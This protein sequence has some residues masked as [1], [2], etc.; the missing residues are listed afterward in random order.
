MDRSRGG[1]WRLVVSAILGLALAA[2]AGGVAG[3]ADD[4]WYYHWSCNGDPDCLAT[5]PT[6]QPSGTLNEGPVQ[7]NCT[8]LMEFARRFWGPA[9]TNSCDHDPGGG[10]GPPPAPTLQ[11]I[12]VTPANPTL[13]LG[14]TRQL[15][16][17]GRYSD[18][19]SRDLTAEVTWTR[20]VLGSITVSSGGLVT[21]VAM[22]SN[23]VVAS[24][25]SISGSTGVTVGAVAVLSLTVTPAAATVEVGL[26][27]EFTAAAHWSDGAVTDV[28]RIA[29]WWTDVSFIAQVSGGLVTGGAPGATGLHVRYEN[30]FAAADVTVGAPTLVSIAVSPPSPTIASGLT[31]QFVATGTWSNGTFT[32]LT[33]AVAWTSDPPEVATVA[34]GGLAT[35][36]GVG[37]AT[38]TATSGGVAGSA[39]LT[40]DAPLLVSLAVSPQ[41]PDA[42]L[43]GATQPFTATGTYT[44]GSTSDLTATASWSS[45]PLTVATVEADGVATGVNPGSAVITA[46]SG[47]LTGSATLTVLQPGAQW[48]AVSSGT[49]TPLAGVAWSG[50]RF[51]VVGAGGAVLASVDGE[52]W[53]GATSGTSANLSGVLWTGT[54][55]VAVGAA[56][57]VLTSPD[58]LAWTARASGVAVDL[59]SVDLVAGLVAAGGRAGTFITSPDG[60]TWTARALPPVPSGAVAIMGM[61]WN[62]MRYVAVG[63]APF[64]G[65]M[66][67]SSDLAA[68]SCVVTIAQFDIAVREHVFTIAAAY[69]VVSTT[70]D[71]G[72]FSWTGSSLSAN[73]WAVAWSGSAYAIVGEAGA[74]ATSPDGGAWTKRTSG[75]SSRLV[76]LTWAGDRLV[77]VGDGGVVLLSP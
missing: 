24:L 32:D 65:A 52:A 20:L 30:R 6:G 13:P 75:T 50:E 35:G 14:S 47:T 12:T 37:V 46:A 51:V 57:T 49:T 68:W 48:R 67:T 60:E 4:D 74:I 23:T 63:L 54:Q 19:S 8:Q 16:A 38:L 15:T 55:F 59:L 45:A 26:T 72:S 5:N 43:P 66:C 39:A 25:G 76:A 2:C 33:S 7:V 17:T 61:A 29:T 10:S 69:G 53:T 44:D 64:D 21:A 22:G 73:L 9:A 56:G 11:S 34:A 77:A 41:A 31:Q 36:R 1:V 71:G 27:A 3:G 28:T 40:V 18:G 70:V 42:L 58:G 62:G